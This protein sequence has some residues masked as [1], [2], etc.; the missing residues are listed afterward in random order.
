MKTPMD[1]FE[2][3][4]LDE[5]IAAAAQLVRDKPTDIAARWALCTFVCFT[6]ELE[7]AEKHLDLIQQQDA[8]AKGGVSLFRQLLRAETAR[9]QFFSEG[10]VPQF[11]GDATDDLKLRL[12]ASIPLREGDA[13]S[14]AKLLEAAEALRAP[15]AGTADGSPFDDFRDLDDFSSSFI[16]MLS[17][18]G[19]Y[20]WVPLERIT[21]LELRELKSPRDLIWRRA[22]LAVREGPDGEVYLPVLYPNAFAE[23]D[24]ALRLG[25][26]TDWRGGEASPVRGVGQKMFL[27]G[28]TP[29]AITELTTLQFGQPS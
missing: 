14:A 26:A 22:R 3:G 17:S 4:R 6:G 28:Q 24:D 20:Y 23:T 18:T 19:K 29:R 15:I 13:A 2:A 9:R 1:H 5:A 10:R 27:V 21:T 7:R 12:A 8:A 16:E 11:I 25:R